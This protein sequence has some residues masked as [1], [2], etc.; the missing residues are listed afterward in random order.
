[1]S[2]YKDLIKEKLIENLNIFENLKQSLAKASE[3]EVIH[4]FALM[5]L[6]F[7]LFPDEPYN[8]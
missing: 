4:G 3:E 7:E 5:E 6:L 1:M 2:D 8:L